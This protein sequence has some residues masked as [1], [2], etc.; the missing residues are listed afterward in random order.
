MDVDA[1]EFLIISSLAAGVAAL[2][3]YFRDLV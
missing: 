3:T 1:V 2:L